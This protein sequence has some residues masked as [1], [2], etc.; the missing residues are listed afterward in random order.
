VGGGYSTQD[1]LLANFGIKERNF[2]G[3]GQTVGINATLSQ[4]RQNYD[5]NYTEPYFQERNVVQTVDVFNTRDDLTSYSSYVHE[6]TG[7]GTSFGYHISEH[8]TQQLGYRLTFDTIKDVPDTASIYVQ[9]QAGSRTISMA[10]EGLAYDRR[11]RK[12]DPS[13]GYIVSLNTDIAG[14]GGDTRYLR[15]VLNGTHYWSVTEDST[16][17]LLGEGGYIYGFNGQDLNINDRFFLGGDTLRGFK[18]GGVGP[19]DVSTSD[20]LGGNEYWRG[21]L[22]YTF[23]V[24]LDE[25]GIKAYTFSDAGSLYHLGF[26]GPTVVDE[27]SPRASVG[28]GISWKSPFGPIKVDIA[29]PIVKKDY[30]ES[31]LFRLGFGTKF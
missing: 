9:Q 20:S 29:E 16:L 23:P 27:S 21:T 22:E 25:E 28:I 4:R 7:A 14:L 31:Q 19:R 12:L 3:Q 6:Q 10:S 5:V 2:L 18:Y 13:Q 24:G 1:G 15:N 30:D 11:D 17:E 8:L 26:S